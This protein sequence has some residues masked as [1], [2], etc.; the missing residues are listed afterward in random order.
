MLR[1]PVPFVIALVCFGPGIRVAAQPPCDA[2]LNMSI[3]AT[4]TGPYTYQLEA[5]PSI[6]VADVASYAWECSFP[7]VWGTSNITDCYVPGPNNYLVTVECVVQDDQQNTC[8]ATGALLLQVPLD[9]SFCAGTT[10]DFTI[11]YESG[12]FVFLPNIGAL[13]SA[14]LLAWDFGD[15]SGS[16]ESQPQH[17]YSEEG[18]YEVCLTV[19]DGGCQKTICKWLY[20]GSGNVQCSDVL[21]P[22]ISTITLNNTVAF[23][24]ESIT[25]GMF[26]QT[27][28]DFGDGQGAVG[29]TAVHTY[30]DPNYYQACAYTDVWGPLLEDTCWT[31]TCVDLFATSLGV[32]DAKDPSGFSL[33]PI[34][35]RDRLVLDGPGLDR[36]DRWT[37][38]DPTGRMVL[39]GNIE[40]S[41]PQSIDAAA[42]PAGPYL[43]RIESRENIRVRAVIKE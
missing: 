11:A 31:Q 18:H 15:A 5:S 32:S 36:G 22:S 12:G 17:S 41:G 10:L 13:S 37:L 20:F 2:S 4:W 24:D 27:T 16:E 19:T 43:F 1:S 21:I 8:I 14:P 39:S 7:G 33:Y 35:F 9:T 34:P 40:G 25:S 6:G 30:A 29:T 23:I 26:H 42:V 38:L 28:W 3:G